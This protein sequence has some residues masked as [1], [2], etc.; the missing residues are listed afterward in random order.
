MPAMTTVDAGFAEASVLDVEGRA[1]PLESLWKDR[2]VVLGFVR[3][4]G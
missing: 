4:F 2:P 3:H 1:V